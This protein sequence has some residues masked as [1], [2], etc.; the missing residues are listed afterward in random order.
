MK[1]YAVRV[2]VHDWESAF[3]FYANILGLPVKFNEPSMGWAEFDIGGASLGLE[4]VEVDD[5]EGHQ[6]VGRFVGISLQVDDID[7]VYEGLKEKGV[8]FIEPP[9]KQ[10]W[11][12]TLAH[13]RDPARNVIT[14]LG[15]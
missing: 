11:G 14:L 12:G 1:L 5:E 10:D 6:L 13:F 4:R 3:D 15:S 9:A 8:E 2:F 7:S